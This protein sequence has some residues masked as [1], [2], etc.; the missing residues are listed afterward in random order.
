MPSTR[1]KKKQTQ[2]GFSPLLDSSPAKSSQPES[3][4][5]RAAAVTVADSPRATKR[6]KTTTSFLPTPAPSSQA[7]KPLQDVDIPSSPSLHRQTRSFT[8]R[9]LIQ[10]QERTQISPLSASSPVNRLSSYPNLVNN[11]DDSESESESDSTLQRPLNK[12]ED[13]VGVDDSDDE[14]PISSSLP[15]QEQ[16]RRLS[17]SE[18][19]DKVVTTPRRAQRNQTTV[20]KDLGSSDEEAFSHTEEDKELFEKSAQESGAQSTPRRSSKRTQQDLDD[21]V[22]FL[23]SASPP[24]SALSARKSARNNA[25]EML[26]RRREKQQ[27][28]R[29]TR[30]DTGDNAQMISSD[31]ESQKEGDEDSI[32]PDAEMQEEGYYDEEEENAFLDDTDADN[33]AA[34]IPLEI[35]L[36]SAKPAQLFE[37]VIEWMVQRRLNP[38]F[39]ES[40]PV[41]ELAFKKIDDYARGMGSSKFQSS[42]WTGTFSRALKARPTLEESRFVNMG[43]NHDRCDACNRSGHPATFEVRFRGNIYSRDTFEDMS[44]DDDDITRETELP[45]EDTTFYIGKWCM[46]NARTAHTLAH[47]QRHLYD[48]VVDWLEAEGYLAPERIVQRDRWSSKKR[49]KYALD[50]TDHMKSI[51]EIRE[52]HRAF[53]TEIETAQNLSV[54]F[55][56]PYFLVKEDES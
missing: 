24:R 9:G 37:Y 56:P 2:L 46:R 45:D 15:R 50:V 26:K 6:A 30:A 42:A 28:R 17:S 48:W 34:Q 43:L 5:D 36:Q 3:I 32:F 49:T 8:K 53:K 55:F 40:H 39:D 29:S 12:D 4:R 44:D 1:S 33:Q 18:E 20:I 22:E 52:L 47:W 16:R 41:Y 11:F 54:S 10:N 13:I 25:L 31:D 23:R 35:K 51:G 21:D 7:V 38:G 27:R 19:S 14:A